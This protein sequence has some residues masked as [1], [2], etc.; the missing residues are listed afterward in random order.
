MTRGLAILAASLLLAGAPAGAAPASLT[1]PETLTLR[2][3]DL[4]PGYVIG[5]RG[6]GS[7]IAGEGA[8]QTLTAIYLD[9]RHLGCTTELMELWAPPGTPPR[10]SSVET[11][12]YRFR[13]A[14]GPALVIQHARDAIAYVTGVDPGSLMPLPA[15]AVG[16]EAVAFRTDDAFV[17]GRSRTRGAVVLWRSGRVLAL[18]LAADPRADVAAA[19]TQLAT[20]QQQRIANPTPLRRIDTYDAEVPLD[21]PRLRLTVPWLGRDFRP[22]RGLPPLKLVRSSEAP[23][24]LGDLRLEYGGVDIYIWDRAR[25]RRASDDPFVRLGWGERCVKRTTLPVDGG[26]AV[27]DAGHVRRQRRCGAPPD[28]FF[29]HVFLRD[30]V[31]SVNPIGCY[32]CRAE[33]GPYD[34]M[35]GMRAI[36]RAL[37]P[38]EQTAFAEP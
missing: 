31:V 6:C 15:P 19:A 17:P 9:H 3:S 35:A 14:T 32:R 1:P 20:L 2:L 16:D 26:V 5:D 36:V 8:T 12:A 24:V 37:R 23:A 4:G 27:I 13:D 30:V 18:A 29:A 33:G 28:R 7:A 34:S 21:D 10:P 11:A 22:G 38:R 25:W